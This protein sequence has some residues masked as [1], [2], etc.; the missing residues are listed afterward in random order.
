[1]SE[2]KTISLAEANNKQLMYHAA[3][4]LG[5]DGIRKGQSDAFLRGKIESAS[6]G[7]STIQF[8]PAVTGDDAD[9]TV[10]VQAEP[11]PDNAT[12]RQMAHYRFDPK[13]EL[14]I[15]KAPDTK[16]HDLHLS[17][18]GETMTVQR[19][20][21]ILLPWRFFLSLRDSRVTKMV[22]TGETNPMT[23]LAVLE[24]QDQPSYQYSVYQMPTQDEIDDWHERTKDVAF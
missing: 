23:G 4:V 15:S 10:P 7:T 16:F 2:L 11:L 8:D 1:M 21:R 22:E 6:P 14:V 18:N 12:P 24:P 9:P 3:T 5:L 20:E 13:V 19:G 17:V